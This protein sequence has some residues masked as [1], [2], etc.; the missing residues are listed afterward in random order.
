MIF[1]G[2][3]VRL[4]SLSALRLSFGPFLKAGATFAFLGCGEPPTIF[5]SF[6]S[7]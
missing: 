4:T 6:P 5:I 1:P 3:K 2:R 7:W